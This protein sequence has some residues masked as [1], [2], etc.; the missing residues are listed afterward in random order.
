M[1]APEP[2]KASYTDTDKNNGKKSTSNEFSG[3]LIVGGRLKNKLIY[4]WL[5]LDNMIYQET[6]LKESEFVMRALCMYLRTALFTYVL[7][8]IADISITK[9]NQGI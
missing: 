1:K 7:T 9:L 3:I 8:K 6:W 5:S 2:N 4:F